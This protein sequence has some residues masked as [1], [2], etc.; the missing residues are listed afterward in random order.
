MGTVLGAAASFCLLAKVDA[1]VLGATLELFCEELP[2]LFPLEL[3][4]PLV[5]LVPLFPLVP[6]APLDP[7]AEAPLVAAPFAD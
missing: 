2:P 1:A 6:L 5:P 7:L 3:L 4:F